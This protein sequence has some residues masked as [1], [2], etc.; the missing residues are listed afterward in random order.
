M[1]F[2]LSVL[3]CTLVLAFKIPLAILA[4][5]TSLFFDK[6]CLTPSLY[7]RITATI[8]KTFE[9]Y[10]PLWLLRKLF[11]GSEK[12]TRG[13]QNHWVKKLNT[14]NEED[15]W[16]GYLIADGVD[17]AEI[18]KDADMIILYA[19]GGGF[20]FGDALFLLD[21]YIDWIKAWKLSYGVRTQ[22]LSLDYLLAPEHPFPAARDNMLECYQWLINE[23]KISPSKIAFAGDSSG[24][25]LAIISA[26][27]LINQAYTDPPA[28][29]ILLS[30]TVSGLGNTRS[31]IDNASND[32]T[33][34]TWFNNS[35]NLYIGDSNLL[36][37]CP[38]ISPLFE[39]QLL[40]L[41]K[42]FACVGSFDI[43]LDDVTAFIGKLQQNNIKTEFVVDDANMHGYAA[44]RALSRGGAYDNT[45]KRIGK[46]L[47]GEKI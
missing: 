7:Q 3:L 47:Y 44:T 36:P 31:F 37:S 9:L 40:G 46:F 43:F 12:F 33:D 18:G 2:I 25:N 13:R 17:R 39:S 8:L 29:L 16:E 27:H 38:M 5:F 42:V 45:V 32:I 19:H 26:I 21:T 4:Y 35:T 34:V 11:S 28:A 20:V 10:L 23:K 41:P 15:G 22:I 30:P 6:E 24:G 14:S 1:D